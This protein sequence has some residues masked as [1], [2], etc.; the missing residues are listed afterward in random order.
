MTSEP[1]AAPSITLG[2]LNLNESRG[3]AAPGGVWQSDVERELTQLRETVGRVRQVPQV[4]LGMRV[5]F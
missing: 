3:G 5:K 4:S 2:R 1:A